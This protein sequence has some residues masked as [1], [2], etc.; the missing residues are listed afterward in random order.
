MSLGDVGMNTTQKKLCLAVAALLL[1]GAGNLFVPI[2]CLGA[3]IALQRYLPQE[4]DSALSA[5][6]KLVTSTMS[7]PM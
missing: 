6:W 5:L 7:H 3:G 2:L 1:C 4:V